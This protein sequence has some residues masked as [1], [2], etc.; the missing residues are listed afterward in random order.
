MTTD[1]MPKSSMKIKGRRTF[2]K[3]PPAPRG[4]RRFAKIREDGSFEK[5]LSVN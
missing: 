1:E 3:I 4:P 5:L 2:A